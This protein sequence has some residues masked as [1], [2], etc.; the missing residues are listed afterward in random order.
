MNEQE[1]IRLYVDELWT[2]R[3]VAD[4]FATN[5]HR[6]RR[7]LNKHNISI[8][9]KQR[10]KPMTEE[11]KQ[12]IVATRK[13]MGYV[14]WQKGLKMD[15]V[16]KRKNMKGKLKTSIDLIGLYPDYEKLKF[17]THYLSKHKIHL[18]FDDDVR[19]AF[20]DKFYFDNQFNR[21]YDKWQETGENK[22][23]FPSLDHKE[24]KFNGENWS[25]ENLQFLT[26][27]ENR[28]KAEMNQDEWEKFK[29]ETNTTSDLFYK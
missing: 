11:H 19:K 22:W 3:M 10:R 13:A 14:S 5:H 15:E 27:F 17:L 18:G 7:I 4:Y 25:I 12:K 21:I 1:V 20:L 29:L 26:W 28:A 16:F 6:I 23:Y 2:L 24:S 8:T 9:A